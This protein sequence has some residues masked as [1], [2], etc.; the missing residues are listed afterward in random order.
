MG[1]AINITT[2][3]KYV[4]YT[5]KT[6][7]KG[8]GL[9]TLYSQRYNGFAWKWAQYKQASVCDVTPTQMDI[10]PGGNSRYR[11]FKATKVRAPF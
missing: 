3:F 8:L 9:I 7:W 2:S 1:Q 4:T 11:E 6:G 10:L 5:W